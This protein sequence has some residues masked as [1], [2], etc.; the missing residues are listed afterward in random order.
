MSTCRRI[1]LDPYLSPCI[2]ITSKSIKDINLKPEMIKLLA[3]NAGSI[4][5]DVRKR[6]SEYDSICPG[7]KASN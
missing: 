5:Q 3:E 1:K 2:K 6:F 4:L 7:I